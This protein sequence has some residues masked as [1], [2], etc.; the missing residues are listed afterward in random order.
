VTDID[1]NADMMISTGKDNSGF[2][3]LE[4]M[5]SVAMLGVFLIP[6]LITHG[7]TV[8]NIRAAREMTRA[9]L[10][11]QSRI[12]TMETVGFEGLEMVIEDEE[13]AKYPFLK[14]ED[15]VT[16]DEDGVLAQ[17]TVKVFPRSAKP[18]K[19]KEEDKRIG[20]DLEVYI[21]NLN[22]EEEEEEIAEE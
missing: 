17:A 9:G 18:G 5:V 10:L 22:F 6:L 15:E 19:N 7:D 20:V 21:V 12:G 16:Y 13:M 4:V 1:I 8:R 3:L 14:M 2:T 11:A